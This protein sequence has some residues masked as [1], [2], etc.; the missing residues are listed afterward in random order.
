MQQ[1]DAPRFS[2]HTFV[3]CQGYIVHY[4]IIHTINR[5]HAMRKTCLA[6]H[7]IEA[8]CFPIGHFLNGSHAAKHGPFRKTLAVILF[9]IKLQLNGS[10]FECYLIKL[11]VK[12]IV[13][14][15]CDCVGYAQ[16]APKDDVPL[17]TQPNWIELHW[18]ALFNSL[19]VT[20]FK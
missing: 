2:Q 15:R 11:W 17:G 13:S 7:I 10:T 6:H 1:R 16:M 3:V 9:L 4:C 8:L 20:L 18:M 12:L 14:V 5:M 19:L